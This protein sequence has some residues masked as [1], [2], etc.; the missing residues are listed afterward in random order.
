MVKEFERVS[1]GIDGLDKLLGGGIP[2]GSVLLVIGTPGTGKT[3]LALQTAMASL[4]RGEKVAFIT[5]ITEPIYIIENYGSTF[6]FFD[7]ELFGEKV[8]FVNIATRIRE[9]KNLGGGESV[10]LS[11]LDS[12]MDEILGKEIN[13][14][15]FDPVTVLRYYVREE[16]LRWALDSIS[17]KLRGTNATV[18]MTGELNEDDLVK[19]PE[20]YL[21]DGI[22]YLDF[23]EKD[24]RVY[25]NLKIIKMRGV[26]HTLDYRRYDITKNGFQ[27]YEEP[28]L[29]L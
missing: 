4:R 16:H 22:I 6:E 7:S 1:L 17:T 3:T 25:R 5:S 2:K 29:D 13:L 21:A 11:V 24:L 26:A 15:I 20:G 8:M 18:I 23:R 19:S 14:V 9:E 12:V 10:V 28:E 27:V